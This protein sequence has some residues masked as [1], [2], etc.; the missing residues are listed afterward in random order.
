MSVFPTA[1]AS[2][3]VGGHRARVQRVRGQGEVDE[4]PAAETGMRKPPSGP[5]RWPR[6]VR[7]EPIC[8]RQVQ[9]DRR[10][11]RPDASAIVALEHSMTRGRPG[12]CS[13]TA[14]STAIP[15]LTTSPCVSARQDQGTR[16]R[17]ARSPRLHR[18]PATTHRN[19]LTHHPAREVSP[20]VPSPHF[21]VSPAVATRRSSERTAA[22]RSAGLPA[23]ALGVSQPHP[24]PCRFTDGFLDRRWLPTQLAAAFAQSTGASA[25][26][27]RNDASESCSSVP[28]SRALSA[29]HRRHRVGHRQRTSTWPVAAPRPPRPR[30]G[31]PP[32][33]SSSSRK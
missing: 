17:P 30:C 12:T 13:P 27:S 29:A 28:R 3:V 26:I 7:R 10:P 19:R 22:R 20:V 15:A 6:P 24:E 16:D 2:G 11:P 5:R 4:N 23:F 33:W 9:A 21:R 14:S 32:R 8:R 18:H 31:P 1:G 25:R